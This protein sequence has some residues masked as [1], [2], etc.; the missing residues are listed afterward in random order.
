M[1]AIQING[2]SHNRLFVTSDRMYLCWS[3]VGAVSVSILD[4]MNQT[5]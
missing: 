4:E 5:L 3:M 1:E 2:E